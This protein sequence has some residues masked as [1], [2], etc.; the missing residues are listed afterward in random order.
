MTEITRP[1]RQEVFSAPAGNALT[2]LDALNIDAITTARRPQSDAIALL[3]L[4]AGQ[5][6]EAAD[7]SDGTDGRW[8]IVRT[9]ALDRAISTVDPDGR[10]ACKTRTH[11]QDGCKAHIV[12][13]P[14]MC[15]ATRAVSAPC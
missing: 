2:L 1:P 11:R 3:G 4:V 9:V 6:V 14:D 15:L 5:D 8:R 13:A 7:D 10:H 12:V